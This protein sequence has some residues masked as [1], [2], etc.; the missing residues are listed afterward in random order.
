MKVLHCQSLEL[1]SPLTLPHIISQFYSSSATGESVFKIPVSLHMAYIF[2]IPYLWKI[3]S[4]KT[5]T[6]KISSNKTD[7]DS[8]EIIVF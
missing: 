1:F 2:L 3:L 6:S 4:F 5:Q 7:E 8:R